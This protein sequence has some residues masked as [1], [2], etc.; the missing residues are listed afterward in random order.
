MQWGGAIDVFGVD[1]GPQRD[2]EVDD[3]VRVAE[4]GPMQRARELAV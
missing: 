4:T 3:T 2:E 1:F